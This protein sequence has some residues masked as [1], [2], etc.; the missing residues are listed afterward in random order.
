MMRKQL[1]V[2]MF[3]LGASIG[4]S[5]AADQGFAVAEIRPSAE[6]VKFEHD[7]ETKVEPEVVRMRDVTIETCIKWAYR[8]QR[9]QVSGP[10]VLTSE[11]YDITAKS[12]APAS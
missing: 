4:V 11:R 12:D 5:T 8:V 6:S 7:G 2:G 3:L 9:S 10:G 1:L